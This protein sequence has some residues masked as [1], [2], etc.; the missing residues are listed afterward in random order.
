M[1]E[2]MMVYDGRQMIEHMTVEQRVASIERQLEREAI[3]TNH[4]ETQADLVT[5]TTVVTD[6][7]SPS[8][9]SGFDVV[10]GGVTTDG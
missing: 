4:L 5:V 6:S 2:H 10:A 3:Y 9:P 8:D 1:I 7:S